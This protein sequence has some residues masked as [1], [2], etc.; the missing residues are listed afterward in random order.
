M[1]IDPLV[2]NLIALKLDENETT[3]FKQ[4]LFKFLTWLFY[5]VDNIMIKYTARCVCLSNTH[6]RNLSNNT[7]IPDRDKPFLLDRLTLQSSKF[8][9]DFASFF[10][11]SG[12]G[13]KNENSLLSHLKGP[14]IGVAVHS[15]GNVRGFYDTV[16][17][18]LH[19]ICR[20]LSSA[21][22]SDSTKICTKYTNLI[23]FKFRKGKAMVLANVGGKISERIPSKFARRNN[24]NNL[25]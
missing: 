19:Y 13:D 14:C 25:N 17:Y 7:L 24:L 2:I 18:Q 12:P 8:S 5:C 3:Y 11:Y 20:I 9:F 1:Q 15:E 23:K 10:V 21:V 6:G 4:Y 16:T 22:R